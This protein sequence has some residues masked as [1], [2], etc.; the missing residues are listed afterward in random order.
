LIKKVT[1]RACDAVLKNNVQAIEENTD[2]TLEQSNF[3]LVN[4]FLCPQYG[5]LHLFIVHSIGYSLIGGVHN[6]TKGRYFLTMPNILT[7]GK[8]L[9]VRGVHKITKGCN[10]RL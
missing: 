2:A 7:K 3:N 4:L 9:M 5:F 8:Q 10:N 6:L 1:H